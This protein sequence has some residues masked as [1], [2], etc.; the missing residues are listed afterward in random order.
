M[1]YRVLTVSRQYGS[2][3][4]EIAHIIAREL[5]WK[6]VDKELIDEIS[7]R[8]HVPANEAAALDESVDPWIHRL[9][10]SIWGR[11]ADGIS[12]FMPMELF[13]AE[14]AARLTKQIIEEAYKMRDCVIV[15]RGSQ[16]ILHNREDVFHAAIYARWADRVSRVKSRV[17]PGTDVEALIRTI[18]IERMKYVQLY[19]KQDRLDPFLY[20]IMIDSKNQPKRTAMLIIS[21]MQSV[22]AAATTE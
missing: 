1:R 9:T 4:G 17:K 14:K 7:R 11:S 5:G 6:L 19:F 12:A 13:D 22:A 16:C 15:G 2:G 20:D 8:E 18:D 3:G 10:R 21:A